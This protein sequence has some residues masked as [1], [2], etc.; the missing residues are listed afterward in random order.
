[1]LHGKMSS[2][3]EKFRTICDISQVAE[4][5]KGKIAISPVGNSANI[6]RKSVIDKVEHSG[7]NRIL[8]MTFRMCYIV[9]RRTDKHL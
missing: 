5:I 1:M 8:L 2:E 7:L 9:P 6:R 4:L 3:T